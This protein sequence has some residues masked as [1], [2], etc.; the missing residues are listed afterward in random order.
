MI[1]KSPAF[2]FYPNDF[3]GSAKVGTMNAEEIGVYM[4][5]LCL[6][7]QEGGFVYDPFTLARWCRLTEKKFLRAWQMVGRCFIEGD[8]RMWNE[9]LQRERK[10]QKEWKNKSSEA[11]K[12]G[13]EARWGSHDQPHS[14]PHA[15]RITKP[16]PKDDSPFPSPSP[17][18]VT[19]TTTPRVASRR[20]PRETWLTPLASA[21]ETV[22]G[23]GSFGPV[24]G[25]F[26]RAWKTLVDA[27]G[28][29]K[30]AAHW[31]HAMSDES[32]RPF[33]TPEY[34]ASHFADFDPGRPWDPTAEAAR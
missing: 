18:P 34:V 6:D 7:W 31:T 10:K 21:H 16:S 24:A 29:E 1:Q 23:K 28:G 4:L 32:R 33:N 11:G 2:Q 27:H 5:L 12:R 9:R 13:A 8:G 22:F 26:A 30:C 3:L 17:T 20:R 14:Q 25:R 19:T 15:R